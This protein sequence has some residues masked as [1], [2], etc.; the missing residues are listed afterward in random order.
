MTIRWVTGFLDTPAA[1]ATGAEEFWLAV[2]GTTPSR[3]RGDGTYATLVPAAGDPY[4][5]FQIVGDPPAR[6][7]IDLHVEDV[8]GSADRAVALGARVT[9]REDGLIV[10]RSPAG[11]PFCL[12]TWHGESAVPAPVSWPGGHRSVVDQICLDIPDG[13]Y[14]HESAFWEKLTS[15][16][17]TDVGEPE[18]ERLNPPAG[19]PLR[20][21]LQRTGSGVAGVHLDL[22]CDDTDAEVARH[23][24]RGATVIR[25][26]PG[27]WST[28]RDP[29]GREYCVTAR[30]PAAG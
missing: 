25:R 22:A 5:R 2:T 13:S 14:A 20:V 24:A 29:A 19:L 10:L 15:W 26:V 28:L 21:L 11:I 6:G 7:H 16:P 23:V 4:L 8:P 27:D 18:F 1:P 17:R 9:H 30:Q 12:N 3:R